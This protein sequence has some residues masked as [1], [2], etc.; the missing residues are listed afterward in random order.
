VDLLTGWVLRHKLIVV[1]TWLVLAV[2]GFMSPPS[3]NS[4]PDK[5]FKLPGLRGL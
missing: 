3:L 4:H 5:T 2:A 1:V